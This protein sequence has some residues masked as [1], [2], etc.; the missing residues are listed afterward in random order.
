[1][2]KYAFASTVCCCVCPRWQAWSSRHINWH[3]APMHWHSL[4]LSLFNPS[5]SIRALAYVRLSR[6]SHVHTCSMINVTLLSWYICILSKLNNQFKGHTR[7]VCA[8][9]MSHHNIT[10]MLL[11]FFSDVQVWHQIPKTLQH[12]TIC[13][14]LALRTCTVQVLPFH[15]STL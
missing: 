2:F 12:L 11:L 14:E 15:F 6:V 3:S 4:S 1:M 10:I 8:E 5:R 7:D 9:W 13:V